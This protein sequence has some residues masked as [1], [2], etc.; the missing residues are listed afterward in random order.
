M[1]QRCP[2][3][4]HHKAELYCL[5]QLRGAEAEA[6]EAH[7]LW[8]PHCLEAVERA[9]SYVMAAKAAC[10]ELGRSLLMPVGV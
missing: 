3:D 4:I 9:Q 7:I 1:P 5:S 2:H 6:F 8:C 10:G